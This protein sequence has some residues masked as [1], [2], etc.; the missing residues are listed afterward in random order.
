MR[1]ISG[2]FKGMRIAEAAAGTRPTTDRTKEAVFS[3][4]DSW[5]YL[6]GARALDLFAGTGALGFEALS[7]GASALVLVDASPQAVKGIAH[8]AGELRRSRAWDPAAM[9]VRVVRG[10]AEKFVASLSRA[11]A[12]DAA[13]GE[14]TG[15]GD[16][17]N[18]FD[19]IFIDPPYEYPSDECAALLAAIHDAGALSPG[20]VIVLER[21]VR[22]APVAL[23]DGWTAL[24]S[25]DY[26]ETAVTYIGA[27][28]D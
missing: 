22:T 10:R 20:G 4:L 6:N 1:I 16:A 17:A 7:R 2:R 11:A 8:S 13:A 14:S 3:H 23:P 15:G 27:V 24:L 25:R 21:S 26:G 28:A 9:S 5:G 12:R 18:V 19:I